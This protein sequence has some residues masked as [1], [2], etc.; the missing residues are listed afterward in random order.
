MYCST[1][2]LKM[3]VSKAKWHGYVNNWK[4]KAWGDDT[5]WPCFLT[6]CRS[7]MLGA[8][9]TNA[10]KTLL[11]KLTNALLSLP[12][13]PEPAPVLTLISRLATTWEQ[14]TKGFFCL[15]T[16]TKESDVNWWPNCSWQPAG[17]LVKTWYDVH[18]YK[19]Y[20]WYKSY[21]VLK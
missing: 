1:T 19:I 17:S 6:T 13:G 20:Q 8:F 9:S 14:R 3:H 12:A 18:L 15:N 7:L 2:S 5:K 21:V 11:Y 16:P 10:V 4:S